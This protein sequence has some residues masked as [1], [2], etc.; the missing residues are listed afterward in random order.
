[1]KLCFFLFSNCEGGARGGAQQ[2]HTAHPPRS[3]FPKP[4]NNQAHEPGKKHKQGSQ[5]Q[6]QPRQ[7]Q[8]SHALRSGAGKKP[9]SDADDKSGATSGGATNSETRFT[10]KFNGRSLMQ[11]DYQTETASLLAL[12]DDASNVDADAA[13]LFNAPAHFDDDPLGFGDYIVCCALFR[14]IF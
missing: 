11:R 1:V 10:V 3:S 4:H 5:Q 7:A 2:R 6:Q 14:S 8:H 9:Q 13:Y 12:R